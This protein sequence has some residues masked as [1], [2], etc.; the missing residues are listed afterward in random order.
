MDSISAAEAGT[1]A[2]AR[3]AVAEKA[4]NTPLRKSFIGILPCYNSSRT[5]PS[6]D[7]KTAEKQMKLS[8][9]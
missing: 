1:A 9:S 6:L 8:P 4:A 7:C 3:S 5:S 2:A